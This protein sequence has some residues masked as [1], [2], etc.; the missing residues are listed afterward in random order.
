[1]RRVADAI[2]YLVKTGCQWRQLPKEFPPWRTVYGYS[3]D[4]GR[5]G[6]LRK[7]QREL[8][9]KARAHVK[10]A[11]YPSIVGIDS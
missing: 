6:A 4:W 11:K 1:M 2:M 3:K 8:Y 7:I 10:R 5:R 9:F